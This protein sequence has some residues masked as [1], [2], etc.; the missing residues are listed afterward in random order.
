MIKQVNIVQ[1][2][3]GRIISPSPL[4]QQCHPGSVL[5]AFLIKVAFTYK[6][7]YRKIK[8]SHTPNII[9]RTIFVFRKEISYKVTVI[10]IDLLTEAEYET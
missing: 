8:T 7:K 6:N 3:A 9:V 10:E 1:H 4:A 2:V 5:F